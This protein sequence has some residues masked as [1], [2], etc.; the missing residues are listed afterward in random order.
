LEFGQVLSKKIEAL[1]TKSSIDSKSILVSEADRA[2]AALGPDVKRLTTSRHANGTGFRGKTK[3]AGSGQGA[4]NQLPDGKPDGSHANG[5][6]RQLRE[7]SLATGRIWTVDDELRACDLW[8]SHV[9]DADSVV[10]DLIDEFDAEGRYDQRDALIDAWSDSKDRH[11]QAIQSALDSFGELKSDSSDE[12]Q[13]AF[14][15][16]RSQVWDSDAQ[17]LDND[18]NALIQRYA[19]IQGNQPIGGGGA[20]GPGSVAFHN[21]L[22]TVKAANEVLV[23]YRDRG[24]TYSQSHKGNTADCSTMVH[25][26]LV[27]AG[28]DVDYTTTGAFA[29]SEQFVKVADPLPGDVILQLDEDS[30]HVGIFTGYVDKQGRPW[31]VQMGV[32]GPS[33]APWGPKG[34]FKEL[35]PVEY[36]RP[37][38]PPTE[39]N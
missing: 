2:A 31:G 14:H 19:D 11:H 28:Y 13:S 36:Y 18:A 20:S 25:D 26:I 21:G 23:D 4:L 5:S 27:K 35:G 15:Q 38:N 7:A 17:S 1:V 39:T 10:Q 24:V 16:G 29:D 34:W 32:H 8:N 37:R 9:N 22:N 12:E 3:V 6:P 33:P 30:G